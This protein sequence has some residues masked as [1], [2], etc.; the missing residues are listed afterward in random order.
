MTYNDWIEQLKNNLLN[1]PEAERQ[2]VLDYYAEAY[3]DR[4]AAGYPESEIIEGFGSPYD[5]AQTILEGE[6]PRTEPKAA[7]ATPSAPKP[8][9]KRA[10][11]V[12]LIIL[13]VVVAINTLYYASVF[14]AR[15]VI[16]A[17][18]TEATYTQQSENINGVYLKLGAGEFK[19]EFYDG[20]KIEIGYYESNVYNISFE[21]SNGILS[22]TV[23]PRWYM[24]FTGYDSP[25]ATTVKLPR[26]K[27][28]G[29]NVDIAAGAVD[30]EGGNF[31][32][33]SID[34]SA[35]TVNVGDNLNCGN[36]NIR[37][38]A[39]LVA[40]GKTECKKC[41]I[42][43]SAG[44]VAVNE[45]TCPVIGIKT[46]AGTVEIGLHGVMSEYGISVDKSAGSCNLNPQNGSDPAKNINI[47]ISAGTV[48]INF[49]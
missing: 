20:D 29:L 14:I 49:V 45:L 22:F 25:G 44:K 48:N 18:F 42:D 38:S 39:G 31:G 47:R 9:K 3:A 46:S 19:T 23:K 26:G 8:K 5:A 28:Y 30:I 13:C 21:E 32:D 24:Y 27:V 1:V 15:A 7:K 11:K 41:N 16:K 34:M 36:L 12:I 4:R 33:I 43:I 2:R 35:G 17:G 37:L 6:Q 10:L 40:V